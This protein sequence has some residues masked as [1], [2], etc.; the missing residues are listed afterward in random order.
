MSDHSERLQIG[1][2]IGGTFTDLVAYGPSD[3]WTATEKVLTTPDDPSE[4]VLEGIRSL[5]ARE[6]FS[7]AD[8]G[9]IIHGT[10]LATN[11][12]IQ[13][14]GP[15]TA[16]VTTKGFRDVLAIAR[17]RHSDVYDLALQVPEPLVPRSRRIEVDERTNMDGSLALVPDPD[18]IGRQ[19]E[20]ILTSDGIKSLAVAL[21]HSYA[22][23]A[24]ERLISEAISKRFPGIFVSIS[25]EV[26]PEIREF[27]RTS[28]VVANAYVQPIL[29]DYLLKLERELQS[30]GYRQQLYV[31]LSSGGI[32]SSETAAAHP[33]RVI[34]S[35]PVGGV[36]AAAYFGRDV[37]E[38]LFAFDMGGTT[39]KICLVPRAEIPIVSESEV[40]RIDP[41]RPGSGFPIL[42]PTVDV[43][44]IGTGGGS[45]ASMNQFGVLK[46]G[47]H[48]AGARPGPA[49]YGRG[50]ENPTTTD[51]DLLLGYLDPDY[52][53]GGEM[54]LRKDLAEA[55]IARI[56]AELD[57]EIPAAAWAIHDV[58]NETM[59]NAAKMQAA[60]RGLDLS[61]FSLVAT[62][63]AGPVHAYG[64]ASKLGIRRLLYPPVAGV[65]SA[66]GFLA[67]PVAFEASRTYE[68]RLNECDFDELREIVGELH[69][70]TMR[71]VASAG[72]DPWS[73]E[74]E[75]VATMSY[76]GQGYEIDVP[77]KM[78]SIREGDRAAVR[79][80]FE[81]V[82]RRLYGQ[83]LEHYAIRILTWRVRAA[84]PN[85]TVTVRTRAASG[86][87]A[88]GH[89][90]VFVND[91]NA[92][93]IPVYDRYHFSVGT[94][95]DGPAII[96]E[97]EST[98]VLL[99]PS[100]A[101]V[102]PD[103]SISVERLERD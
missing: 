101:E 97:K 43:V 98:I 86:S 81:E 36:A 40:A 33:V 44:E 7:L 96:E 74:V 69:A 17:E 57:R 66:L 102:R 8:V 99:G 45:I 88:K 21:L 52:F 5:V 22:N 100:H 20:P 28:T 59:A 92:I 51:A 41:Q 49:C 68:T 30:G 31:M 65:V 9:L 95:V 13:R 24:N 76:S 62:G 12:I 14:N 3:G 79:T 67:S 55:A 93:S 72:V 4:G 42:A 54:P 63:G 78:E 48:S 90:S 64:I 103:G 29:R 80:A 26:A 75:L 27:E 11:T 70:T 60:K 89:R 6:R 19:M 47:P 18:L 84:G 16:L 91:R 50:G 35:G 53:V 82:Y 34:E 58:A 61:Q 32:I 73:I 39:A 77:L 1:V 94:V 23:P 25:C 46:V 83:R 71:V 10:T 2:D 85:P 15:P 38:N 56:A 87:R 37:A